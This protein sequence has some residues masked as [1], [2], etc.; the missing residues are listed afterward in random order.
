MPLFG[1][2][3]FSFL[4]QAPQFEAT[5][6]TYF[7]AFRRA[8]LAKQPQSLTGVLTPPV[9]LM[10]HAASAAGKEFVPIFFAL[11][12]ALSSGSL[13]F[14][15]IERNRNTNNISRIFH[16]RYTEKSVS[17]SRG[18]QNKPKVEFSV[19]PLIPLSDDHI[20]SWALTLLLLDKFK[21]LLCFVAAVHLGP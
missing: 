18:R 8:Q 17:I 3:V 1:W 13:S 15:F 14:I 19:S 10:M 5:L 21:K 7:S 20:W 6:Y 11:F 9:V 4:V 12:V 2:H 16:V